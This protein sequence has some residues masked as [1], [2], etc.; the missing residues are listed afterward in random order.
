MLWY[1]ISNCPNLSMWLISPEAS[2]ADRYLFSLKSSDHDWMTQRRFYVLCVALTCLIY[3]TAPEG[4]VQPDEVCQKARRGK[5]SCGHLTQSI[6]YIR[7]SWIRIDMFI[8]SYWVFYIILFIYTYDKA[9][10]WSQ[11]STLPIGYLSCFVWWYLD[12]ISPLQTDE[13]N[14]ENILLSV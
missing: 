8:W 4:L 11:C 14:I 7:E 1:A 6:F 5:T 12:D 2:L 9:V 3:G 10:S 13:W